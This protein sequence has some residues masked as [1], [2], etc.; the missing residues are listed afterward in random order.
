MKKLIYQTIFDKMQKIGILD[1]AGQPA[2]AEYLKIENT[3]YMALNLDRLPS[4]KEGTVRISMAHNYIQ[5]GDVMADPDMEIRI[6][7]EL[8]A[9]E[10]LTYQQDGLGIYQRVYPEPGMVSIRLK[11]DLN[12]FLN[13][14]L[15]NQIQQGF[16]V[17]V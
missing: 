3:P 5:E 13:R 16:R 4:E 8:K 15:S 2:F 11:K 12:I 1:G 17:P 6:Y 10:A 9:A 14:W 7:P